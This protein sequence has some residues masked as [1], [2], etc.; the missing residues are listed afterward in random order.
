VRGV[1][2]YAEQARADSQGGTQKNCSVMTYG[3]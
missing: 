2:A 1:A 3:C